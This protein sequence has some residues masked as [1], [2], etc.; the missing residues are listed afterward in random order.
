M[1]KNILLLMMCVIVTGYVSCKTDHT[2]LATTNTD[3]SNK[4][5][6]SVYDAV[7][8]ATRNYVYADNLPLTGAALAIGSTF[9]SGVSYSAIDPGN[10]TLTIK[11]TLL[12]ST[13][14]P[15]T[16]QS[17]FEAG[18]YYSVF[19]YDT[20]NNIKY[21]VVEDKFIVPS[22]TTATMRFANLIYSSTPVPNVDVFSKNLNKVIFQNVAVGQVTDFIAMPTRVADSFFVQTTGTSTR[23]AGLLYTPQS[24]RVYTMVFRGS[25]KT[26]T[27]TSSSLRT[28]SMYINR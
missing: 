26:A 17:N 27:G 1:R 3:L 7:V 6:V 11:D 14:V 25:Y 5:Q 2:L 12:T 8:P 4:A 18:K 10:R 16:F 13:Q 23:L 21:K 19:V 20:L 22:D 28:L 15:L 9:P 24:Q